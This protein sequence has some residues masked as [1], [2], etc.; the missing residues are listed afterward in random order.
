MPEIKVK[1]MSCGHCAAAVT[2]ALEGLPGVSEVQVDLARGTVSYQSAAPLA[3]EDL[4]RT[5]KAAGYELVAG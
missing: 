3:A 4:A 5:I 2:K 1:G